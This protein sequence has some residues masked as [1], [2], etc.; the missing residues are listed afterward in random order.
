MIEAITIWA[1]N[2]IFLVLFAA[3]LELLLPSS[4]MQKFL[5]VIVGLLI[6]LAIL[7]PVITVVEHNFQLEDVPVFQAAE[8][9]NNPNH[10]KEEEENEKREQLAL[11]LYQKELVRQLEATTRSIKGVAAARA[12][13]TLEAALGNKPGTIKKINLQVK[14]EMNARESKIEIRVKKKTEALALNTELK[15]KIL[16]MV[17][18]LYQISSEKIEI[19]LW[20]TEDEP[21]E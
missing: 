11:R 7:K 9:K 5:R 17:C 1:K 14:P 10:F 3:F 18:E 4:T 2:L 12:E 21:S 19:H 16:H 6:M 20:N 8:T 15:N 13:V